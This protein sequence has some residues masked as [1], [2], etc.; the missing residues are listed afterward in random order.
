MIN[1]H[2]DKTENEMREGVV[3]V[4]RMDICY[5]HNVAGGHALFVVVFHLNLPILLLL[6]LEDI[7]TQRYGLIQKVHTTETDSRKR[8]G[9]ENPM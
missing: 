2:K 6:L 1:L 8:R 3:G 4:Q 7:E 5:R 9:R